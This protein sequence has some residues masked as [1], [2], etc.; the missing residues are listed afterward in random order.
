MSG[1]GLTANNVNDI[2]TIRD[3]LATQIQTVIP[4]INAHAYEV[5]HVAD[6]PHFVIET[7]P[8]FPYAMAIG[9]ANSITIDFPCTLLLQIGSTPEGWRTMDM[10]RAPVGA[11]SIKQ[12]IW[13]DRTLG[14]HVDDST[15]ISC[16]R[17]T[18]NKARDGAV[19]EFSCEFL[20][21]VIKTFAPTA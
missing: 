5:D 21:R 2:G 7:T 12:A 16:G 14:G 18:R 1:E 11:K 3:A 17:V 19:Y 9:K 15:V 10:Y 4:E 6:Y 13:S 20:I 8:A